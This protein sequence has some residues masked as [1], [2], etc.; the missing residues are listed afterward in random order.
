[1]SCPKTGARTC[2]GCVEERERLPG[3][4][5]DINTTAEVTCEGAF[6]DE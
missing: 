5:V 6:K 3:R 1:M 4:R 2:S